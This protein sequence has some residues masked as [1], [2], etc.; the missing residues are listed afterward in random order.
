MHFP[1]LVTL[2]DDSRLLLEPDAGASCLRLRL[3]PAWRGPGRWRL[4]AG[5][6]WGAAPTADQQGLWLAAAEGASVRLARL[7]RD[8]LTEFSLPAP[9]CLEPRQLFLLA[10]SAETS[11][12]WSGVA[13]NGWAMYR[14][15][16]DHPP[17]RWVEIQR[18][19]GVQPIFLQPLAQDGWRHW[20]WWEG[21]GP[22]FHCA[23]SPGGDGLRPL[24]VAACP[25]GAALA[26]AARHGVCLAW[27]AGGHA[28]ARLWRPEPWPGGWQ[29][30]LSWVLEREPVSPL[31]PV[32]QDGH[33]LI[34]WQQAGELWAVRLD[35]GARPYPWRPGDRWHPLLRL[36]GSQWD[37]RQSPYQP[38]TPP[39]PASLR[40]TLERLV[41]TIARLEEERA[42]LLREVGRRDQLLS[43][44]AM[45][46][47][48]SHRLTANLEK[49]LQ[50]LLEELPP[51][52]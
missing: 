26:A 28:F 34:T 10:E 13:G 2:A 17:G 1:V 30:P 22:L 24:P 32:F 41:A 37:W 31:L 19:E 20:F 23:C 44:L 40:L 39:E 8:G 14:A 21:C 25:P 46:L 4:L 36:P 5:S 9:P 15:K 51:H 33:W 49:R 35:E 29:L 47:R 48:R 38:G 50:N 18:R 42:S 52:S 6:P 7:A 11:L 43:A 16:L 12:W 3:P 27:R 45:E